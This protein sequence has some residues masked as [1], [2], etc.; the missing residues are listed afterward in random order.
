MGPPWRKTGPC[1][2]SNARLKVAELNFFSTDRELLES[3]R[4]RERTA[5]STTDRES[6][7]GAMIGS[8]HVAELAR[9]EA[10]DHLRDLFG[11]QRPGEH[12]DTRAKILGVI[13]P[14]W[15]GSR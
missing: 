7:V 3:G 9:D 14:Q 11:D 10:L 4:D 2:T 15:S 5:R 6:T 12:D 1:E 8:I 13:S